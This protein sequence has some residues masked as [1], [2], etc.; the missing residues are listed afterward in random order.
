MK[1]SILVV[2]DEIG[3]PELIEAVLKSQGF[4]VTATTNSREA[5][6][7]LLRYPK[8]YDLLITDIKMPVIDGIT[9][10]EKA[11]ELNP[12]I[13]IICTTCS[14]FYNELTEEEQEVVF[15]KYPLRIVSP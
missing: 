7:L 1:E 5:F 12:D 10:A 14:V 15:F 11:K 13:R 8:K 9:L 4:S 3:I 6:N 2:D